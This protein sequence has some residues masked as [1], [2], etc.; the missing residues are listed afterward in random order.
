MGEQRGEMP[1]EVRLAPLVYDV[2][3]DEMDKMPRSKLSSDVEPDR[4]Y[5]LGVRLEKD[6]SLTAMEVSEAENTKGG[7]NPS[8][9]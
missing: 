7:R 8:G 1:E 5:L 6:D 2:V 4:I 3:V 9:P